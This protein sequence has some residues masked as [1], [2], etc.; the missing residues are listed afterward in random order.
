MVEINPDYRREEYLGLMHAMQT[1]VA[2]SMGFMS[3][4]ECDPKHLRVG[5][6]SAMCE[7]GALTDLLMEKG[8]MTWEEIMDKRIEYMQHEVEEYSQRLSKAMGSDVE[9]H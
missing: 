6:N 7:L 8:I 9:L 5:L 2:Y 1:G 3:S 4:S